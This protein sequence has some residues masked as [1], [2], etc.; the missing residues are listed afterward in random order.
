MRKKLSI[1]AKVTLWYAALMAFLVL[2]VLGILFAVSGVLAREAAH[3]QLMKSVDSAAEQ[4]SYTGGVLT[5][6]G[7][8]PYYADGVYLLFYDE[9]Y[10]FLDGRWPDGFPDKVAAADKAFRIIREDVTY[11][12][13]DRFL[14]FNN[15]GIWIRGISEAGST[16]QAVSTMIRF[17]FIALPLLALLATV[18]GWFIAKRAFRP[19]SDLC[20]QADRISDG[21]DLSRRIALGD[22]GDE[23]HHLARTLDNMLER[24]E[25]SF[26][27]DQ[28][29]TSDVAHELRTPVS[30]ILAECEYALDEPLSQAARET[31]E[32]IQ[33]QAKRMSRMTEEML[34]LIRMERRQNSFSPAKADI[35]ELLEMVCEEQEALL[36]ADVRLEK[37][38]EPVTALVDQDM[39]VRLFINLISNAV[40]YGGT[41]IRVSLRR[42]ETTF[43]VSVRDNGVGIPQE[44]HEKIFQRFYQVDP[45]RSGRSQGSMGLGLPMVRQIVRLHHGSIS[46][47]SIPGVGSTFTVTLPLAGNF[48]SGGEN[49]VSPPE[50]QI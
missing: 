18:G 22:G 25:R 45:S 33:R 10:N 29:F 23:L 37:E 39:L 47:D 30:V 38:L 35:K 12:V 40:Q 13:Y 15:Q 43:L 19:V 3:Q 28:Q 8:V 11:Y 50:P 26:E 24:L 46:L 6:K 42:A 17:L 16:R 41:V 44:A 31:L 5:A 36:E 34:A 7:A 27:A 32:V 21:K 2:V 48:S 1:K 14:D 9:Q 20:R 4:V 49:I